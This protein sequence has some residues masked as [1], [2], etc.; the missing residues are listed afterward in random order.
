LIPLFLFSILSCNASAPVDIN[1]DAL[2]HAFINPSNAVTTSFAASPIALYQWDSCMSAAVRVNAGPLGAQSAVIKDSSGVDYTIGWKT[3]SAIRTDTLYP[4]II[5]LHGGTGSPLTTKGEKAYDMLQPLSDS[6]SLFLASPSANRFTP[7]WSPDG[8]GRILQTLRFMTLRYPINPEKVFLAGV[9]DGATACYA[10]VN[11]IA[12]P[13]AGFLAISGFGG[14]LPQ[15][16]MSL[17]PS[18]I[19]Q[20]PIYNVNAGKDRIYDLSQVMQFID[21][22]Q[23][24]G[25]KINHKE[26]PDQQHGFDYRAKEFGTLATFIRTW[27][28]P[29]AANSIE[30]TFTPGFPYCV[31][32][33]VDCVLD[34]TAQSI[35]LKAAL[36]ADSLDIFSEGLKEITV[37]FPAFDKPLLFVNVNNAKIL[38]VHPLPPC[39]QLSFRLMLHSGFPRPPHQTCYRIKIY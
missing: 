24:N 9:S 11:T 4:L 21:W 28:K 1:A 36:H 33:L 32:N 30:W 20:R 6:F 5:Y 10:A 23:Q 37:S 25:V 22:L 13:F 29:K 39:A 31:D 16:S 2:S 7:W 26:Y 15:V 38:K 18:N 34:N 12:G 27:S 8:I 3:P 17:V 19:G 14:M 35:R